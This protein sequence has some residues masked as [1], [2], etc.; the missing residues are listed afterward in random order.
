MQAKIHPDATVLVIFGAGGDLTWRKLMPALYSLYA[1]SWLP[2][3]FAVIGLDMKVMTDDEFRAH[4]R[5]GVDQF[6]RGGKTN[7]A[8]WATFAAS[9]SF[10][11]ANFGD[12]AAYAA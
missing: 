11:S 10:L 1:D 7:D 6:S 4:L 5:P 12:A 3:H 8:S 9:I 2:K